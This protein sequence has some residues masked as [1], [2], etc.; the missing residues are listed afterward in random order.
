MNEKTEKNPKGSG[1]V[2]GKKIGRI[3]PETVVFY[4]R[5]TPD[6]K[7]ALEAFLKELRNK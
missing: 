3:K 1:R 5:V 4:K 2:A 6:E 7:Q